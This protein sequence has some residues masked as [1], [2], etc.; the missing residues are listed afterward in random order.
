MKSAANPTATAMSRPSRAGFVTRN[1]VGGDT[2]WPAVV[3]QL[4][5]QLLSSARGRN[6]LSLLHSE[7]SGDAP[8]SGRP[9]VNCPNLF[10]CLAFVQA[11]YSKPQSVGETGTPHPVT[12]GLHCRR[13]SSGRNL[14]RTLVFE[15]SRLSMITLAMTTATA[16]T[17]PNKTTG[18]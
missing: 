17:S 6:R 12:C 8:R 7:H 16:S 9:P 10:R 4:I 2:S 11:G 3:L 18:L 15:G 1:L 5:H 14:G 13:R